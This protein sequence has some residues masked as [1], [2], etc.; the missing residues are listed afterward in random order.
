MEQT[1]GDQS[2]PKGGAS[3]IPQSATRS[4]SLKEC[5]TC[6]EWKPLG[7]FYKTRGRWTLNKC[8]QCAVNWM[9]NYQRNTRDQC[10]ARSAKWYQR[11]RDR[12]NAERKEWRKTH[13]ERVLAKGRK[14]NYGLT[15]EQWEAMFNRQ[16]R[17]CAICGSVEPGS[18]NGWSTDHDHA[19]NKVRGILCQPCNHALGHYEKTLAPFWERAMAYLKEA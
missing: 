11:H 15:S 19:S 7:D 8:K 1:A 18:K 17:V 2:S 13:P 16:G 12:V 10:R 14:Y 3:T 5:Q 6:R 9:V 4:E